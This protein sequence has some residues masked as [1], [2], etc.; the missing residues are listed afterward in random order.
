MVK[1]IEIPSCE[2]C[3]H[4]LWIWGDRYDCKI[5]EYKQHKVTDKKPFPDWC[6]LEEKDDN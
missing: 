6:S 4:S 3:I 1:I 2:Q 5:S